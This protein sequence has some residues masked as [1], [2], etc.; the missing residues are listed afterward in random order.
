MKN[1]PI[2][3]LFLLSGTSFLTAQKET[4][5]AF[6][7]SNY[8]TYHNKRDTLWFV[9]PQ[10]LFS[11]GINPR[12]HI[13]IPTGFRITDSIQIDGKGAKE[14]VMEVNYEES[15]N[16]H[17]GTFDYSEK[18]DFSALEIWNPDT[19]TRLF[20]AAYNYT[21]SVHNRD[22][23]LNYKKYGDASYSYEVRYS[24]KGNITISNFRKNGEILTNRVDFFTEKYPLDSTLYS[25]P[26]VS[27]HDEDTY[28]FLYGKYRS[29]KEIDPKGFE[30]KLYYVQ[31]PDTVALLKKQVPPIPEKIIVNKAF[32]HNQR[33]D[34]VFSMTDQWQF[35]FCEQTFET[36]VGREDRETDIEYL[37]SHR[38]TVV[39]TTEQLLCMLDPEVLKAWCDCSYM[40]YFLPSYQLDGDK[41]ILFTHEFQ[42][43][44]LTNHSTTKKYFFTKVN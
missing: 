30:S 6:Q 4:L 39:L 12:M 5:L 34:S 20:Q 36:M 13:T 44:N 15:L 24:P 40:E 21:T 7:T 19:K 41:L 3:L 25:V 42:V 31:D 8:Y 2:L 35:D 32:G 28:L 11:K 18:T 43:G 17:G 22:F 37:K 14:L 26:I 33:L 23:R 1:W 38:E 10:E 9:P 27:D 16:D 29:L